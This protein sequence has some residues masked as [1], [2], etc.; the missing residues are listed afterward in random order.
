MPSYDLSTSIG[1]LLFLL[2]TLFGFFVLAN[3]HLVKERGGGGDDAILATVLVGF[4]L[5][6]LLYNVIG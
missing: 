4:F 3:G 1:F 5:S 6:L 2:G